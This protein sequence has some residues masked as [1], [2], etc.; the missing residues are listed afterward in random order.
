M[1]ELISGALIAGY[2]VIALFFAKFWRRSGDRLFAM[3]SSAFT[4]L[5]V[6]RIVLAVALASRA[7]VSTTWIYALRLLAFLIILV[8]IVDKN[9]GAG[10]T[11]AGGR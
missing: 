2:A 4:L 9:R 1:I 8:A 5:A 10:R 6:H 11:G 3:F 7:D